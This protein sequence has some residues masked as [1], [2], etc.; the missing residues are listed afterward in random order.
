[1]SKIMYVCESCAE[2]NPEGCG[3]YDPNELRVMPDGTWLCIECVQEVDPLDY[4][5]V[6]TTGALLKMPSPP[7][8]IAAE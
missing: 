3:H 5:E 8:F 4:G 2:G 6:C 1:M 7:N